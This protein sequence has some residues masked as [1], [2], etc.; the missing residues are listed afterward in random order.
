MPEYHGNFFLDYRSDLFKRII[1][2]KS[3]EP[4]LAQC[5]KDLVDN[6]RDAIDI[7][8]NVGFF[9]VLFAKILC[10]RK[11]LSIEP[12]RHALSRLYKNIRLNEVSDKTIVFEGVVSNQIGETEIKTI[13]GKEEYSSMGR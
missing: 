8:A 9:T 10:N 4:K 12:T 1:M 13:E 5:C 3:Y 11:V 7:G 2:S 6:K